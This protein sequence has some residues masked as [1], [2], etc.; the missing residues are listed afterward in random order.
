MNLSPSTELHHPSSQSSPPPLQLISRDCYM[1][2]ANDNNDAGDSS[3]GA[4]L[5]LDSFVLDD[6][7]MMITDDHEVIV[8]DGQLLI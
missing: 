4:V 8:D 7:V 5:D 6:D 3:S 2:V 1:V